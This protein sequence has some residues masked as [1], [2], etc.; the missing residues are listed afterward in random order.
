MVLAV[1]D[2]A[3]D[4]QQPPDAAAAGPAEPTL[5]PAPAALNDDSGSDGEGEIAK[6]NTSN[7]ILSTSPG[8]H[9]GAFGAVEWL[10]FWSVGTIWGSSFLF[11]D[12]GLDAFS[13][14][15]ITWLRVGSGAAV[16]ALVPAAR[17]SI[18]KADW[19]RLITLSVLWVGVP[20]TLFP[21]AQ[22]WISSAVAGMLN[23]A[24]PIF[25]AMIASCMLRKLPRGTQ[26]GGLLLGFLGVVLVS[27]PSMGEGDTEAAGVMLVLL[28]TLCYGVSV[29]IAAPINQKYGSLPVM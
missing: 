24:V 4:E 12:I 18:D 29:N 15:L 13:P 11:M 9:L 19:P 14:G 28:A 23:G 25:V 17:K 21:I 10:L 7:S 3:D 5:S 26:L 6:N 1:T 20:F 16:L 2:D 22:Q 8:T 27:L